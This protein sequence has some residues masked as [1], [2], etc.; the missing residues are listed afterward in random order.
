MLKTFQY[1]IKD[2][3]MQNKLHEK[4]KAVNTVWNFCNETQK[5]ALKW[6]KRWPGSFDMDNLTSGSS[7]ELGIH[8][9]TVQAISKEYCTRRAQFNKPFLR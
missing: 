6:R 7:K 5:S 1:R 3:G 2:G 4:A 9:T 8:S